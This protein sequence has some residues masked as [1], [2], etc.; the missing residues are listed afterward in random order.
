M[1]TLNIMVIFLIQRQE[2]PLFIRSLVLSL[3]HLVFCWSWTQHN[4]SGW[5]MVKMT[6][7]V[8]LTL[9]WSSVRQISTKVFTK[10]I[11]L[12]PPDFGADFVLGDNQWVK[13]IL[14]LYLF[15]TW[16]QFVCCQ[17]MFY[18]FAVK[19]WATFNIFASK[20]SFLPD[21]APCCI[22]TAAEINMWAAFLAQCWY[23]FEHRGVEELGS[24]LWEVI[25]IRVEGF[26]MI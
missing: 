3:T 8:F 22:N 17:M 5:F 2:S 18:C 23:P 9:K 21:G 10:E 11:H 1:A 15:F 6:G 24:L 20:L 26:P 25:P 4:C 14:K 13:K 12:S 19:T 7:A 16:Y